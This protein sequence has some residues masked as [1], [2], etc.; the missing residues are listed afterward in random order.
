MKLQTAENSLVVTCLLN[1]NAFL[2]RKVTIER[3]YKHTTLGYIQEDIY[4]SMLYTYTMFMYIM[5]SMYWE[6]M[7]HTPICWLNAHMPYSERGWAEVQVVCQETRMMWNLL[8]SW[9]DWTELAFLFLTVWINWKLESRAENYAQDLRIFYFWF[10]IMQFHR[11]RDFTS[12]C[13]FLL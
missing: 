3:W 12:S 6:R 10:C 2:Y 4:I 7:T 9:Q 1:K 11:L 8:H 13:W 5:K